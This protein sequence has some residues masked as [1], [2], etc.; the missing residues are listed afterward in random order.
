[1]PYHARLSG[2][3]SGFRQRPARPQQVPAR[4]S[5]RTAQ[6]PQGSAA[7]QARRIEI[8]KRANAT[9][10]DI[11]NVFQDPRYQGRICLFHYG[12]HADS[13]RLLLES[14]AGSAQAAFS[15]GLN[16]FFARQSGLQAIFLNG[17]S[18]QAQAQDLQKSGL[19]AVVAT[20][21]TILDEHAVR[22][23][24]RF[25]KGLVGNASPAR[26]F[27]D[28]ADEL[29]IPLGGSDFRSLCWDD[30]ASDETPP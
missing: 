16:Q 8:V 4:L 17:C 10:G 21:R 23:A 24:T 28:A 9:L 15:E 1:M 22:F 2:D 5:C 12:G 20:S 13:Y 7:S 26:A 18:T 29:T 27:R 19:P 6:H 30:E 3:I 25:Y 11:F 14:E